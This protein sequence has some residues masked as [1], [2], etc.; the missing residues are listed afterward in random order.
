[1]SHYREDADVTTAP[2]SHADSITRHTLSP[3]HTCWGHTHSQAGCWKRPHNERHYCGLMLQAACKKKSPLHYFCTPFSPLTPTGLPDQV[4]K[5]EVT[6]SGAHREFR[7]Y[8]V[9]K[10]K[11]L[12]FGC[13]LP[14]NMKCEW[15]RGLDLGTRLGGAVCFGGRSQLVLGLGAVRVCSLLAKEGSDK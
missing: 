7:V 2:S 11:L 5:G 4:Y 15:G 10:L 9:W 1:M 6:G 13:S 12:P 8:R 14:S 3:T